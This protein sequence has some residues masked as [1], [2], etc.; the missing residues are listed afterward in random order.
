MAGQLGI[1]TLAVCAAITGCAIGQ[2]QASDQADSATTE[3]KP[4]IK[5]VKFSIKTTKGDIEGTIFASKTPIT[6]ANFCNLVSQKYYDGI[7]FHRVIADFM[8]Q[9]GDPLTKKPGTEVAWG[10]GGPGYRFEDEF[11]R[12]LLHS[13]PGILSMANAGPR[14]NGSQIFIT[15]VPTPHL[16]GKHTVFGEVTKG[17]DIV[18]KIQKGDKIVSAKIEGDTGPLFKAYADRIAEWNKTL[19]KG[20]YISDEK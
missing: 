9:V 1:G 12:D 8:I 4:E 2:K 5:D 16:D 15:H 11:R 13:K 18:N 6:A 3:A 19:K 20:G 14:T 17:Q 10:T 7:I